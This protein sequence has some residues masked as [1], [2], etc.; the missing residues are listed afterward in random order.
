MKK[1]LRGAL[2]VVV[3]VSV[4]GWSWLVAGEQKLPAGLAD[5]SSYVERTMKEFEVPGA[6]VAIVKDGEVVM[7]RG[8]GVRKLGEPAT[9]DA[10]TLFAIASNTKAFTAA[11]LAILVDEGKLSWDDRVVDRLPG[12]QMADPFVT[13]EMRVRDLWVHRRGLSLG[14]GDLLH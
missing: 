14:A 11:A 10:H 12:F 2:M 3:M 7:A 13:R 9:V 1:K 6:A 5:F 8:F 4:S